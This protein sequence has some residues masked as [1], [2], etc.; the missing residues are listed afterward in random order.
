MTFAPTGRRCRQ[1]LAFLADEGPIVSETGQATPAVA[2][3]IGISV[4]YA[5]NVLLSL[6]KRDLV[7]RETVGKRTYSLAITERG[8]SFLRS[9]DA[10]VK[11]QAERR[12]RHVIV[13]PLAPP[14]PMPMP[15][16]IAKLRF[17]AEAARAGAAE[18]LA[19]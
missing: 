19:R 1:A 13:K 5:S 9:Q 11:R 3:A 12:H 7:Q 10:I 15:G 6:V 16:P 2:D 14:P 8:R 18:G 17:D 4:T